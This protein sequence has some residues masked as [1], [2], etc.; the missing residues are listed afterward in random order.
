MYTC[1]CDVACVVIYQFQ[2]VIRLVLPSV[3]V[4][5]PFIVLEVVA[6]AVVV[7]VVEVVVVLSFVLSL[8][9]SFYLL[10]VVHTLLVSVI[11]PCRGPP[12]RRSSVYI[13]VNA[14][15]GSVL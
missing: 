4:L 14:L 7:V 13:C 12:P 6:A 15:Y 5:L 11:R 9:L 8:L 10:A 1:V 3:L 2:Y